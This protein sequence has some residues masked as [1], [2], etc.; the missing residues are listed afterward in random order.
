MEAL[1][2]DI[3]E[4]QL[5][6]RQDNADRQFENAAVELAA[7]NMTAEIPEV[8]FENRTDDLVQDFSYRLQSQGMSL[9]L[10]LQY[11]GMELASF[12]ET[13]KEQAEKQVK[14]R[15]ALE[16]IVALEGITA[17]E[18]DVEKELTRLSEAYHMELAQVKSMVPVEEV[19]KDL[20][21]N[22]AIDLIKETAVRE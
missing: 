6:T 1:R 13:F 7:Q 16:K 12:R 21:V 22:K 9:D 15:L 18:E 17:T 8:M 14:I 2:A 20:A 5:K 3:R 4:K 19:S 11:T 10:Y